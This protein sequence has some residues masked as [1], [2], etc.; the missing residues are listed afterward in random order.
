MKKI[1]IILIILIIVVFVVISLLFDLFNREPTP[2]IAVSNFKDCAAA[3]Y[4]VMES[5]PRQC[6]TPQGKNFVEDVGGELQKDNLIRLESPRPNT[7]VD[8]PLN[9]TGMARGYWFFEASFPVRITDANGTELGVAPAQ[10][11]GEWMTEEFVPFSATLEFKSPATQRGYLILEKDNPSG[12]PENAD[13]LKIP[14]SFGL[15]DG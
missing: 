9:I 11:E 7:L 2:P 12:L 3:G 1:L 14:I 13:E 15:L 4:P 6:R 10:A 8:S 5:Y